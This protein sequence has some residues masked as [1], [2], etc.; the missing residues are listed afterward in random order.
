MSSKPLATLSI[1]TCLI[2]NVS[3]A[4]VIKAIRDGDYSLAR[5]L[6]DSRTNINARDEFGNTALHWAA[7]NQQPQLIKTLLKSGSKV[8]PQNNSKATP[9]IYAV[10]NAKAVRLLLEH[11]ANPNHQTDF[12]TTPIL[13][14]VENAQS[15]EVIKLLLEQGADPLLTPERSPLDAAASNGDLESVRLLLA[16][17]VPAT[18]V[19]D[20]AWR[21]YADIVKTLLDAGADINAPDQFSGNA[22]NA[23][24]YGQKPE[25]AKFLIEQGVDLTTRAPRGPDE[26]PTLLWAAYN[27]AGDSSVAELM[28]HKGA[29]PNISSAL[30]ETALDWA[31]LRNNKDLE[32]V[33]LNAGAE[34]G[35]K[36]K[37]KKQIPNNQIPSDS[38]KRDTYIRK[39][40]TNGI[41]IL[42]RTSDGYLNAGIVQKQ[43][44]VSCHQQTLPAIAFGAAMERGFELDKTSIARQVQDQVIYWSNH[45]RIAKAYEMIA[46]QPNPSVVVGYGLLGLSALGYPK[47]R[48]IDSMARHLANKQT[49]NGS[50][51]AD[52]V[53]PP[54][55]GGPIVGTAL[56]VWAMKEWPIAGF[57]NGMNEI[58]KRAGTYLHQAQADDVNQQAF[59]LLGLGISGEKPKKLRKRVNEL[60]EKQNVDGGWAQLEEWP[61]DSW[62]TGVTLY[63]LHEAGGI[64]TTHEAYQR[65]IRFLLRTQFADGSWYVRSRSWPFQPHFESGFPHGKDQWI[66]TGGT[67]WAILA[68]LLTQEKVNT[69]GTIDW[70]SIEVP[71]NYS[72]SRPTTVVANKAN[73]NGPNVSFNTDIQPILERSCYGCHSSKAEKLKGGFDVEKRDNF[74]E[75][76][77][78]F[79][80]VAIIGQA[81]ESDLIW[82][83]SDQIEDLEMPPLSKREKYPP[84]SQAEVDAFKAWINQGLPW[85]VSLKTADLN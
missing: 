70:T 74:L 1:L 73:R 37:K 42:Q 51:A 3:S 5:A 20:P 36:K 31:R 62:A 40:I 59:Q 67:A 19:I 65:G 33:L 24:L 38:H 17:G 79:E 11:G 45:N 56:G 2:L 53:R 52:D 78:S 84:L 54:M 83:I 23:A 9:L 25:M 48:L 30:G 64:P 34:P 18:N 39:S 76:G 8:D 55:E 85:G 35:T 58:Y 82:M 66:S 16:S 72:K 47:D 22:L 61:S 21:G 27:I 46:P 50:W 75:G 77:Q 4:S 7:L 63:A 32:K 14:A 60:L 71:E 41:D 43:Q 29:D 6:V 13:A 69:I 26:T 10:G 49:L 68:L 44:C 81:E 80:P 15:N 12:G 28:L 57:R